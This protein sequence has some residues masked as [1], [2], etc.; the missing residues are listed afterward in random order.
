MGKKRLIKKESLI[1]KYLYDSLKI[2]NKSRSSNIYKRLYLLFDLNPDK[3]IKTHITK[4][5]SKAAFIKMLTKR[6]FFFRVGYVQKDSKKI[7]VGVVVYLSEGIIGTNMKTGKISTSKSYEK[8]TILF[9][10]DGTDLS[11]IGNKGKIIK[12]INRY[13]KCPFVE[14]NRDLL[15]V[16][17]TAMLIDLLNV[18]NKDNQIN[19]SRIE[20]QDIDKGKRLRIK[21][22]S[23]DGTILDKFI[24]QNFKPNDTK[25]TLTQIIAI[26]FSTKNE[27]AILKISRLN[28]NQ[29]LLKWKNHNN[30]SSKVS[31]LYKFKEN[32]DSLLLDLNDDKKLLNDLFRYETL[33]YYASK[34]IY[35]RILKDYSDFVYL[36]N[37][38]VY[39][40][41]QNIINKLNSTLTTHGYKT[42]YVQ[43]TQKYGFY[44]PSKKTVSYLKML[45]IVKE[46]KIVQHILLDHEI[47][48]ENGNEDTIRQFFVFSPFV[49]LDFR[50]T[51]KSNF[52]YLA[53]NDYIINSGEFL[54]NLKNDPNKMFEIVTKFGKDTIEKF[55]LTDHY[56]IAVDLLNDLDNLKMLNSEQKGKLFE[57]ICFIILSKMFITKRLGESLKPDGK[58][59]IDDE[60]VVYDAKNLSTK[61]S[62]IK[63]V[64][65]YGK[66]KDINYIIKER[67]TKYVYIATHLDDK[68]FKE[69]KQKI[70]TVIPTCLVSAITIDAIKDLTKYYDPRKIDQEKLKN[71][72][73]SGDIT[74]SFSKNDILVD[75]SKLLS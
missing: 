31:A 59:I 53:Y 44:L 19:I 29:Y 5:I 45:R 74:R 11:I 30:L 18:K 13:F 61:T 28:E 46:G 66:V 42:N 32:S 38:K 67:A 36:Q 52:D 70:N 20:Y 33:S 54:Y 43:L 51:T 25:Y 26:S 73:F 4:P 58:F 40:N 72:I 34:N 35:N 14:E 62:F 12:K 71:K 3:I 37:N 9:K 64:T 10:V 21:A 49:I 22:Y 24:A 1:L 39:W 8:I 50:K 63:S 65:R 7:L 48:Y 57:T 55:E 15:S 60:K 6:V 27:T 16:N 69:V 23:D 68:D 56:K 41:S 2:R 17:P 75:E 47:L